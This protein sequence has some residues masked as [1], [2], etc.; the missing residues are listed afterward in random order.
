MEHISISERIEGFKRFYAM[1]NNEGPLVGFF[2]DTYY[3]LKRYRAAQCLREGFIHPED[4]R[5]TD[6]ADDYES[7]FKRYEALGGDFI[8]TSS[9]FWGVPWLEAII[10]CRVYADHQTGS[11]RSQLPEEVEIAGDILD[12]DPGNSWVMKAKEF[13]SMLADQS[14]GRF[15]LGITLMRG[16]SDLFAAIYGSPHFIYKLIDQPEEQKK[17][18]RKLTSIWIKFAEAQFDLIPDFHNGVGSI[19][20]NLWMPGRGAMLQEDASALI[21][22]ELFNEFIYPSLCEITERFD[23]TIIHLHPSMYIPV[24]F[25]IKTSLTAIEL[26]IDFGGPRAEE[27]FPYYQKILAEKPLIIWGD[28]TAEDLDFINCYLD[29]EGLALVPVVRG[30]EEAETIWRKFKK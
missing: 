21:S 17:I 20:Y 15:P 14:A 23:S 19:F 30:E 16:I 28:L 13:L 22:P 18:A 3:P 7:L 26:H 27:L 24:D 4:I 25:L 29:K 11:S 1:E 2:I 6:F 5:V 10:G 9:A 12:F 8:W